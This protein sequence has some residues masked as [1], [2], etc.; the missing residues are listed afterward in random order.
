MPS[1]RIEVDLKLLQDKNAQKLLEFGK[2]FDK[3]VNSLGQLLQDYARQ[4]SGAATAAKVSMPGVGPDASRWSDVN[5]PTAGQSR[6]GGQQAQPTNTSEV[7]ATGQ[8]LANSGYGGGGGPSLPPQALPSPSPSSGGGVGGGGRGNNFEQDYV[9]AQRRIG[10]GVP[11]SVR[12]FLG[13]MAEGQMSWQNPLYQTSEPGVYTQNSDEAE[14]DDDGNAQVAT[15][16][17]GRP[18]FSGG[19]GVASRLNDAMFNM[20][21]TSA[22]VHNVS[23]QLSGMRGS[24]LGTAATGVN[25][26]YSRSGPLGPLGSPAWQAGMSNA[27]QAMRASDF[28]L[29]FS[30]TPEQAQQALQA[31][32]NAGWSGYNQ[33]GWMLNFLKHQQNQGITPDTSMALIDPYLRFGG[34]EDLTTLHDILNSLGPAAK[35]ANMNLAEFQQQVISTA[36]GINQQTG[37]GMGASVSALTSFTSVTGL[38]PSKAAGLF[39]DPK[40][41]MM[42]SALTGQSMNQLM[43]T[44]HNQMSAVQQFGEMQFSR[45]VGGMTPDEITKGL[46][47]P[48]SSAEY[49]KAD[50]A[51]SAAWRLYEMNPQAF[52]GFSPK[53]WLNMGSRAGSFQGVLSRESVMQRLTT[54]NVGGV[55]LEG[56]G[57]KTFK[58]LIQQYA[59]PNKKLAGTVEDEMSK[60]YASWIQGSGKQYAGTTKQDLEKQREFKKAWLVKRLSANNQTAAKK[61]ANKVTIGLSSNAEKWF[62]IM[63]SEY[64]SNT[65]S[66]GSTISHYA[67]KAMDIGKNLAEIPF[68][69]IAGGE[70][71]MNDLGI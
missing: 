65:G 69:P 42:A 70:G 12:Q 45:A 63:N 30:Y 60:S 5:I 53:E 43:M 66:A 61:A 16:D 57:S 20:Q 46:A 2:Q 23:S 26:G 28:G 40:N 1:N 50:E 34:A 33:T 7:M 56:S 10:E 54:L 9:R 47:A 19:G 18:L 49:K 27:F 6:M 14:R 13:Y 29:S 39:T 24:I 68:D 48:T 44:G 36:E 67:R 37:M 32:Q 64:K 8:R 38:D 3:S 11:T 31:V 25:L 59:G 58:S 41:L 52:G 17:K 51:M 4:V 71:L 21:S 35:A 62:K 15:D 55:G 22:L